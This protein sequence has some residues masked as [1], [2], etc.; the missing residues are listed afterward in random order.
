[1]EQE[2]SIL[3]YLISKIL[4]W[5]RNPL[6][7]RTFVADSN[8]EVTD[9]ISAFAGNSDVEE[10]PEATP[11]SL[12]PTEGTSSLDITRMSARFPW[13]TFAALVIALTAQFTL[14]PRANRDWIPGIILYG[15]A[16]A[17]MI[18][19]ILQK[20]LTWIDPPVEEEP[21]DRVETGDQKVDLWERVL[22]SRWEW[23]FPAVLLSLLAFFSFKVGTGQYQFTW[24]NVCIWISALVLT[25]VVFWQPDGAFQRYWQALK[26]FFKAGTIRLRVNPWSVLL[27]GI[28]IVA[29]FFRFY[30]LN[31]VPSQMVS[32]HAEKLLD[33]GDVLRGQTNVY[34]PRNTGRE[35]FQMYWTALMVI[36]FKTGLS[37]ISLKLGT[38]I[39]GLL[40]LPYIY[41]LGKEIG[42]RRIGLIA[43]A[44]A[45]IA[46][47]P[48]LI[49]RIALRFTL[50][51]FFLAPAIYYFLRGIR[52]QKRNDFILAGIFLGLGLH[53]YSPYRIVPILLVLGLGIYLI[54]HLGRHLAETRRKTAFGV[55]VMAIIS[56][57][58]FLPLLRYTIANP[59]MVGYRA[60]TRLG[61]LE[62][63]IQGNPWLIFFSNLWRAMTMF[64]WDN[65]EVWVI[66][67]PHRPVLDFVAGAL[68]HLG[69]AGLL[70]RYI[71]KRNWMD[72]FI[73]ISIPVLMLPSILSLAFP[74]E[75]PC[76][77]R[78]A[79]A[80]IPVF[81]IIGFALDGIMRAF[82]KLGH[83]SGQRLA[84]AIFIA[85]FLISSIQN[86]SLVFQQYC[87]AYDANSWN[88]T[89]IG[90][91]IRNYA[92]SVGS[93]DTAYLVA[94]PHWVDSRLVGV[95]AGYPLKDFAIWTDQ[96]EATRTDPRSKLFVINS[97]DHEDIRILSGMYPNGSLSLYDV[98]LEGKDFYLFFVPA[99]PLGQ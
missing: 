23:L 56:L 98:S 45:G 12:K 36:V 46:Y 87:K 54:H 80:I 42:N 30:L 22:H 5:R 81:L 49:S 8:H 95:N 10:K 11:A 4:F 33:V 27:I 86:Y 66:S 76:L 47:W 44:F 7:P 52:L 77:N 94:Y 3:D 43:M 91:V 25:I 88:T 38:V 35:F 78:T 74:A 18:W 34:F 1:M 73:L 97:N 61:S 92:E 63:P 20:E 26:G 6:H 53:G 67:I 37:F 9:D 83:K 17:L 60:L 13:R 15:A 2:P 65:G 84:W 29:I 48:N 71:Q 41:L 28:F 39:L 82:E 70:I 24:F 19:A 93:V 59:D 72:L 40:T 55:L 99:E 51:P 75:N 89:D 14:E 68:F 32:D 79:G 96:F 16:I 64:A 58:I 31:Q 62:Q 85:L 21:N 57:V 90:H 50:Y 69:F